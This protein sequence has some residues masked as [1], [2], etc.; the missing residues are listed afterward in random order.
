[1]IDVD[2]KFH[3]AARGQV[4]TPTVAPYISFTKELDPSVGIFTLDQSVLDGPDILALREPN[5]LQIWDLY[6]YLDY[7]DRLVKIS[8]SRSIEFPYTVQIGQAD[9]TFDNHDAY[10]TPGSGSAIDENNLPGRPVRIYAGFQGQGSIPQ[11]V[12][13]TE[14]TPDINQGS[15]T[16][17]YHVNDFLTSICE[18]SLLEVVDM[19]DART[20]EVLAAIVEQFGLTSSQYNF[21]QGANVIP[22]VF[23][24]I[25]DN[26]GD[27]IRKLVQAENGRFWL[28][29]LGILL[30]QAR[31]SFNDEL[32]MTF[33]EYS[34]IEV[35]PSENSQMVNHVKIQAEIREVQ[36]Y[37]YVYTKS[38]SGDRTSNLWV[39][40]QNF[41]NEISCSLEDP[42][43]DVQNPTLGRSS[44]VSWFTCKDANGNPVTGGVSATSRLTSNALII[45]FTNT[46]N[47][48]VEI[49]EMR[50]YGE[51]AKVTNLLKYDA[52]DENSV[53]EYGEHILEINNNEF[54]QSED[55]ADLFARYM[56]YERS[57]YNPILNVEVKGD[58]SLMLGDI[59]ELQGEFAGTYIVDGVNWEYG[60]GYLATTLT[61]HQYNA[62]SYF[63]LDSSTLDGTDV[64]R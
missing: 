3:E 23:F 58:F 17:D 52:Q 41:S 16:A 48:D 28:D 47:F 27:A 12:G 9:I 4:I 44:N 40:S 33:S 53:E 24:D 7:S 36:E 60:P 25:G 35:R 42:C 11:L 43:Y 51:P 26:A 37:Q 59:I 18:S 19:R 22:F 49:D 62:P 50:L 14:D 6:K 54:F 32:A 45:T 10:F 1:M 57:K 63:T 55:Q 21:E 13:L 31:A 29:E 39:I 2:N 34:I 5:V 46:N 20:D 30:F 8:L 64:L 56:L 61:V 15:R 38:P